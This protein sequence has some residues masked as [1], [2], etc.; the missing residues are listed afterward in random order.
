[1]RRSSWLMGAVV[2]LVVACGTTHE[3][4]PGDGGVAGSAQAGTGGAAGSGGSAGSG[5]QG[6]TGGCNRT[7]PTEQRPSAET[8]D[9]M[10]PAYRGSADPG[11]ATDDDAG[12]FG[13]CTA[14]AQCTEGTNGRCQEFRGYHECTY[15]ECFQD[16][17]CSQGG[18]CGCEQAFWSDANS[19]LIGNCQTDADCGANGFC[20]PTLGECGNYSGVIG[21]YCHTCEDECVN[22]ADCAADGGDC[23]YSPELG[24][25]ACSTSHCVG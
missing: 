17:E 3:N 12:T 6:G 15:D 13:E 18:P 14:D 16:G 25:W 11:G 1:M 23:R 7:V 22:D 19:C 24:H 20:S 9:D 8:C 4:P 5:G 10:R 21:Y 2:S